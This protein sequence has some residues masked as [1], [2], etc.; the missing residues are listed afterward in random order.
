MVLPCFRGWL[1]WGTPCLAGL[2]GNLSRSRGSPILVETGLCA[3]SLQSEDIGT[4]LNCFSLRRFRRFR[5]RQDSISTEL[6]CFP[7]AGLTHNKW[8][9]VK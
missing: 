3:G 9:K 1:L 4:L 2:G 6:L 5:S 8:I 7:V